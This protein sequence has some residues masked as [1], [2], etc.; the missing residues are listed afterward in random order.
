MKSSTLPILC[1]TALAIMA[2]ASAAHYHS[3]GQMVSLA[4]LTRDASAPT[5]ENPVRNQAV[6]EIRETQRHTQ[7]LEQALET[8]E[9]ALAAMQQNSSA[10]S[11]VDHD[12]KQLLAELVSQNRYLKDQI[13]ETNRDMME[14]QFRV[15]SHSEQFRPLQVVEEITYDPSIGVLPPRDTP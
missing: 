7:A 4:G 8:N 14:L 2:G 15:D 13:A 9:A 1:G 12:L 5:A 6:S 3:V 11:S 10:S